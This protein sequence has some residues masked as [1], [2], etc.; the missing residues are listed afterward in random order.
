MCA[1]LAGLVFRGPPILT[2][3]LSIGKIQLFSTQLYFSYSRGWQI[4]T[5]APSAKWQAETQWRLMASGLEPRTEPHC[6]GD[7]EALRG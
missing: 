7:W 2:K 5:M 4:E 1:V 3:F 6:D